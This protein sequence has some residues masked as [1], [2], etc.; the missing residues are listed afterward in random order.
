MTVDTA[1]RRV[2][3]LERSPFDP[4]LIAIA[5]LGVLVL[6]GIGW[7]AGQPLEGDP[8]AF[9]A[10]LADWAAAPADTAAF[11]VVEVIGRIGHL[12][13]VTAVAVVIAAIARWRSGRWDGALLLMAVLGGA[14]VVTGL[15]KL[16]IDRDRP[17]D[18]LTVTAA[19]P[20]G[21]AVRGVA[22]LILVG[23]L[24]R[25]WSRRPL[26]RATAIPVAVLLVAVNGVA[27]VVLGVHWPT[28]VLAGFV[29]G[30]AWVALAFALVRPTVT[31]QP[32]TPAGQPAPS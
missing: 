25:A 9:D 16:L 28:D 13:V 32:P 18:S 1:P 22:V 24:V 17:D 11:T 2:L 10:W 12:T 4:K 31:E 30:G 21:H 5:T 8:P 14:T 15:L 26:V 23:W 7:L 29:L 3:H 27:R 20:S 19:F 6:T